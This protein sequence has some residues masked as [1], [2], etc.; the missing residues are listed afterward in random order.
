MS[1]RTLT[2]TKITDLHVFV[3]RNNALACKTKTKKNQKREREEKKGVGGGGG[4]GG[5]GGLESDKSLRILSI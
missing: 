3:L 4:G 5:G 1:F 2:R